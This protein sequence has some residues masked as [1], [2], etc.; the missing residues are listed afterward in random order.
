[1]SEAI[2]A[3]VGFYPMCTAMFDT[4][5]RVHWDASSGKVVNASWTRAME[6]CI[7]EARPMRGSINAGPRHLSM[8]PSSQAT[9]RGSIWNGFC[10]Q[11]AI[12]LNLKPRHR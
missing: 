3:S 8:P 12:R 6:R 9:L 1:M 2:P 4:T 5:W 11:T 10:A 7:S